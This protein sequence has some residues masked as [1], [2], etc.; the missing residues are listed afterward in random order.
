MDEIFAPAGTID[1][2]HLKAL[3]M[4]SDA[5]GIAQLASHG[6]ALAA[7]AMADA[8][9]LGSW[10]LAPALLAHG[11]VLTFL[12]APLHETI[13]RTA[14]KRRG[15]NDAVAWL[16]GVSLVLPPNFFRA[17]HFA[18]HRATQD[19]AKDPELAVP[20]PAG[21]GAYL[22]TVSGLPFWRE[23]ITTVVKHAAG[24]V[25][26][27][28][29]A[30]HQKAGMVREARLLLAVY[31]IIAAVSAAAGSSSAVLYWLLPALIGQPFLRLYLLAEHTGCPLVP[32]MLRNS[33]TTRSNGIVRWLAWNM[34][35]HYEQHA[36]PALPFHAL[37]AA[38][39]LIKDRI[40]VQ[41]T[42]YLAVQYEIIS[43]LKG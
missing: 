35:Y 24:K 4:R 8:A 20:K 41:A 18:H 36:Y 5:R 6:A 31:G 11:S 2:A 12:F 29:I 13:H 34:P 21:P 30:G 27:P 9:G 22:L 3:A 40:A 15:L 28:F 7:T 23:R 10:W 42:G 37:P 25:Q 26:E 43:G 39:A 19:P 14:F 16:C 17:F 32:D 38:H 1:K 33:R